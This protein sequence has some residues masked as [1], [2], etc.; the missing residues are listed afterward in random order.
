MKNAISNILAI[1]AR[2]LADLVLYFCDKTTALVLYLIG[3]GTTIFLKYFFHDVRLLPWLVIVICMDSWAGYMAAKRR[4][5]DNPDTCPEVTGSTFREKLGGKFIAYIIAL[6]TLNAITN[7]EILGIKATDTLDQVSVLGFNFNF[8]K[9]IYY[10][11]VFGFMLYEVRSVRK[12]LKV[13]GFDFLNFRTA[14][15]IDDLLGKEDE[16]KP[17]GAL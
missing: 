13:L 11:A 4:Y 17:A 7:F 9:T 5:R 2:D 12:N 3:L 1:A 16:D 14:Q 15:S 8:L 10:T 6:I